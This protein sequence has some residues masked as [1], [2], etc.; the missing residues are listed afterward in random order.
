MSARSAQRSAHRGIRWA[1]WAIIGHDPVGAH[2]R[3]L[4]GARLFDVLSGHGSDC[5]AGDGA[6]GRADR[7]LWGLVGNVLRGLRVSRVVDCFALRAVLPRNELG[8]GGH[9]RCPGLICCPRGNV[10]VIS[11]G[12]SLP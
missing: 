7:A 10:V 9:F 6:Y 2:S 8:D 12:N 11:L 3:A 1:D 4:A 5:A